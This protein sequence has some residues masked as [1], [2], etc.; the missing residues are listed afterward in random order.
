MNMQT[1]N[2]KTKAEPGPVDRMKAQGGSLVQVRN[3]RKMY[4]D[5]AAVDNVSFDAPPNETISLLGPSGCGKTTTLR[6]LAGLEVPTSGEITIGD[7]I[8]YSSEKNIMVEPEKRNIGMVF[9]SYAIWPH[10]TVA[11][12]V[13]FPLSIAKVNKSE[14]RERV[15][16]ILEL[17]GLGELGARSAS[18]LS[19]GQQQRVAL[20]R[21]LVYTPKVVLF[22][23]PLS[24]LDANLRERM[25][26]ELK[27][28]QERLNF[29][30]IFVTH[31]QQEALALS[32]KIVLMK[33]GLI[34]Q[35]DSPENVFKAPS[36]LFSAHF[37]GYS[38][39]IHG[40]VASVGTNSDVTVSIDNESDIEATWNGQE[41]PKNGDRVSIA[42]RADRVRLRPALA[43]DDAGSF[44][45]GH[46]EVASFLGTHISY[47]VNTGSFSFNVDGDQDA[48]FSRGDEVRIELSRADCHAYHADS[49]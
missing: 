34:E 7:T 10:M 26:A 3:L 13:G 8:V 37:L 38:N 22:D 25:R 2:Q 48:R 23:E 20:A 41:P 31:D 12:N 19:G 29:T 36:T 21:A 45:S 16:D 6:C 33:S 44:L 42:V 9:Q 24:N 17:V 1:Q 30:S 46:I 43:S 32:N 47:I 39:T 49:E 27:V 5:V 18:A 11:N 15:R 14:I 4:G 28:L 35:L 40:E